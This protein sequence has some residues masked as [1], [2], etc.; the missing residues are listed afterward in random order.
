MILI[1]T[2]P[3]NFV[4]HSPSVCAS[5]MTNHPKEVDRLTLKVLFLG[6][7]FLRA[8]IEFNVLTHLPKSIMEVT[9]DT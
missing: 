6:K 5:W 4:S 2:F 1:K 8:H 9:H 3:V 7:S